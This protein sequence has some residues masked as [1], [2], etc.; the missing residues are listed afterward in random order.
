MNIVM[1]IFINAY[2]VML[3]KNFNERHDSYYPDDAFVKAVMKCTDLLELHSVPTLF[4]LLARFTRVRILNSRISWGWCFW[5]RF[6]LL[7]N[8]QMIKKNSRINLRSQR[9]TNKSQK[10][11]KLFWHTFQNIAHLLKQKTLATFGRRGQIL[12]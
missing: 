2:R 12:I 9:S 5:I 7:S 3:K 4:R 1:F 10:I 6:P 8:F 11:E